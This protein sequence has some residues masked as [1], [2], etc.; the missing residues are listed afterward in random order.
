MIDL[1]AALIGFVTGATMAVA[2]SSAWLLLMIPARIQDQ[3]R[4]S[5]SQTMTLALCLGLILIALANGANLTLNLPPIMGSIALFFGG[6]FVGILA[7]AL[8]EILEAVPV[9]MRRFRL[10]DVSTGTH[11]LM[12]FS[13]ALGALIATLIFTL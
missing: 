6:M 3:F 1:P 9:M 2:I 11:W 8:G 4:V 5:S 7:S 13:K 10:G 12:L